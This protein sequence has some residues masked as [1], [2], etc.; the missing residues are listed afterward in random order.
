[1]PDSSTGGY[2]APSSPAPDNDAVLIA[3]LQ[4]AVAGITGLP[5]TL[6]LPRWQPEPANRPAIS[7]DWAALGTTLR[8]ANTFS[9]IVHNGAA[10][11]TDT[12]TRHEEI[13]VAT[14]FYGPTCEGNATLLRD[15]LGVPQNREALWLKGLKLVE[16]ED[17]VKT[18]DL[19]N[20]QWWPRA[21]LK[22]RIRRQ[23]DR[24]YPI[25]NLESLDAVLSADDLD[26]TLQPT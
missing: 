6:I 26:V 21:D 25:L 10:E 2:L 16:I 17:V 9:T 8:T 18:A 14:S 3:D 24:T 19:I 15:G 20:N 1:M 22:F 4:A 5:G 7:V 13:D 11:G 12:V 23:V